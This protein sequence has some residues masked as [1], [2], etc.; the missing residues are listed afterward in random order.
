MIHYSGLNYHVSLNTRSGT[1][2]YLRAANDPS[3]VNLVH[4]DA[5]TAF[6]SMAF[7]RKD[8]P[9]KME[10]S[11]SPIDVEAVRIPEY[12]LFADLLSSDAKKAHFHNV[13]SDH[14]ITYHFEDT[15]FDLWLD[16]DLPHV[17]QIGIDCGVAFM[18]LRQNETTD[19]QFTAKSF[20]RSEDRSLCYV[21]LERPKGLGILI[22]NLSPCAGWRLRYKA[23]N[24]A[25]TGLEMLDRFD[26]RMSAVEPS[27]KVHFGL[28]VSFH[29]GLEQAREFIASSVGIPVITAAT[30]SVRMGV[31][32][33]FE[34]IGEV[35]EVQV[36]DPAG[37]MEILPLSR[38]G[39]GRWRG[40]FMPQ[41][42]G[43]HTLKAIGE[44][45]SSDLVA[46]A[47]APLDELLHRSTK[48]LDPYLGGFA[49][50]WY[51]A[52]AFL[53]SR[54][55][56]GPNSRHDAALHVALN[57]VG[58]QGVTDIP[59]PPAA[60]PEE[61]VM[62]LLSREKPGQ[63]KDYPMLVKHDGWYR[64]QPV[65][66]PQEFCGRTLQ[67]FHIYQWERIQD[68]F[69]HVRTFLYASRAY[70]NDAYYE[71]AISVALSAV[72]DNV[73]E[74]GRVYCRHLG[75]KET[76]DYT[77]VICPLQALLE[78]YSEMQGR[79]DMRAAQFGE[80]CYRIAGYLMRRGFEFP[81]EGVSVHLRWTEDGS[82]ACAALALLEAYHRLEQRP[83]WLE[84][85]GKILAYHEPW[86]IDVPDA[87]ILDSSY[88][89]WETQWEN[90]GEG[91]SINC[92]HPWS[93]WQAEALYLLALATG[94]ARALIQSYN[95]FRTN[96]VKITKDGRTFG[97]FTPDFLPQRP[98][99]FSLVH[100]YPD[101]ECSGMAFYFWPRQFQ[102]W[103]KTAAVASMPG[104]D[105]QGETAEFIALQA[106]AVLEGDRL[107]VRPLENGFSRFILCH[108]HVGEI[109]IESPAGAV[110]IVAPGYEL[111]VH[112][113]ELKGQS[114]S[115]IM[116][117]PVDGSLI[118]RVARSEGGKAWN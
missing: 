16:G 28:R 61:E 15:H 70:G 78:L 27:G 94:N 36:T 106:S 118:V 66:V 53:M 54:G 29:E 57:M 47:A 42:E 38:D 24:H 20:Y 62:R 32:M 34:V 110:E 79:G 68:Q 22:C 112:I 74:N 107:S 84:H 101:T 99:K 41:S 72:T 64:Y 97:S 3:G 111:S 63:E 92:G 93:L 6:G 104:S 98:R 33:G 69:E 82:I 43:F 52:Q 40:I 23:D 115:G 116:V 67:P 103:W 49:E 46:H 90:D 85:A 88:R 96:V 95:G 26:S 8:D 7:S 30:P 117:E 87:R 9:P 25:V 81:T 51:W 105:G 65:P 83:E 75:G 89:Y 14:T 102:T 60:P 19:N 45:G 12:R 39:S 108:D 5:E 44:K 86:R 71:H 91:R 35:R 76:F 58:M 113:G 59:G 77:T 37:G 100:S 1:V 80:V 56:H 31:E 50:H 73:D 13:S 4:K 114:R 18:D 17:D 109:S 10:P 21:Y 2:D 55:V 11:Q 48:D